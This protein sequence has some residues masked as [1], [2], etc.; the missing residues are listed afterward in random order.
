MEAGTAEKVFLQREYTLRNGSF[1]AGI[2][3]SL[4]DIFFFQVLLQPV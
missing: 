2:I 4:Q 3:L 1:S